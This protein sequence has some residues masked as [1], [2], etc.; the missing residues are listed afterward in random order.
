MINNW[1]LRKRK[2]LIAFSYL[3]GKNNDKNDRKNDRT[4]NKKTLKISS[5]FNRPLSTNGRLNAILRNHRTSTTTT[6]TT[7][8]ITTESGKKSRKIKTYR[9]VRQ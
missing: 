7:T 6:T 4:E 1:N 5:L 2:K 9:V 3:S 8:I